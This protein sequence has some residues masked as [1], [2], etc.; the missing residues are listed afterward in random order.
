M[1]EVNEKE[2]KEEGEV[3]VKEEERTILTKKK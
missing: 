3:R 1:E 2:V